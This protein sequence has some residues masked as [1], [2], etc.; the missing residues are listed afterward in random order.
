MLALTSREADMFTEHHAA[1]AQAIAN[2]PAIA[3]ENARLYVEA[4]ELAALEERQ[5]LARELHDSVSQALYGISLGAHAARTA[6]AR[7]PGEVVEP[8]DYVLMLTEAALDEMRALIFELRPESL[9]AEGLVSALFKQ[10]AALQARH[11]IAVSAQLC[12]EPDLPIAIK[13]DLYRIAQ[14]AMHNTVK[15]AHANH[16]TLRLAQVDDKVVLEV[17]D[18]GVGFDTTASY[19]GHLGLHSMR[20]RVTNLGGTFEIESSPGKGTRICARVPGRV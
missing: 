6:L 18:D 10:A 12:D 17:R 11:E 2:Q 13:K 5:N 4:Q 3:I 20:E 14:E 15:H 7:D 16:V 1:L 8:L 19:Q 9:E